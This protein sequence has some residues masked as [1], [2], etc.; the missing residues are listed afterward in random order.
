MNTW[1]GESE[2]RLL[3]EPVQVLRSE[4]ELAFTDARLTHNT[5]S[6]FQLH[7]LGLEIQLVDGLDV[8][9]GLELVGSD[10][11]LRS[12]GALAEEDRYHSA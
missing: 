3:E 1:L 8:L 5:Q 7:G 12:R 2:V 11:G 10:G 4:D 9:P 6:F